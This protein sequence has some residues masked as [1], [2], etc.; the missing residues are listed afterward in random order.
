MIW[1]AANMAVTAIEY[2]AKALAMPRHERI[3]LRRQYLGDGSG[4]IPDELLPINP[5]DYS[6]QSKVF[7]WAAKQFKEGREALYWELHEKTGYSLGRPYN[8]AADQGTNEQGKSQDR[9][10]TSSIHNNPLAND[11]GNPDRW[12]LFSQPFRN[13]L[14]MY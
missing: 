7:D 9:S 5:K 3:Q 8:A 2:N 1:C 4:S 13:G 11:Y 10:K 12:K 6:G 14:G